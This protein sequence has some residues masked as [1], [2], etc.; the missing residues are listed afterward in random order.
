MVDFNAKTVFRQ[1]KPASVMVLGAISETW[2]SP[3]IFVKH[4]EKLPQN[5]LH[6]I[7]DDVPRQLKDVISNNEGH[8][9]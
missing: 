6:A 2:K 3:L 7:C 4:H 1:Q 8:I 9:E 5:L